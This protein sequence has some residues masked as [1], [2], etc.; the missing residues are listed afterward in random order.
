MKNN[1]ENQ[2]K[3]FIFDTNVWL[4]LYMFHPDIIAKLVKGFGD[5][6]GKI[7]IPE[8]VAWETSYE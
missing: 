2:M 1:G 4:G 7:W 3:L 5:N 6:K 8:Q